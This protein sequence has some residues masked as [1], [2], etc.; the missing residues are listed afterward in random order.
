MMTPEQQQEPHL[1]VQP[2]PPSPTPADVSTIS[3]AASALGAVAAGTVGLFA[4]GGAF[5]APCA[6]A[7][8]CF[9][10][11]VAGLAA[12]ERSEGGPAARVVHM[13]SG[14][15]SA[16]EQAQQDAAAPPL[17]RVVE[18]EAP[19]SLAQKHKHHKHRKVE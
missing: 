7:G 19:A 9:G 5:I 11:A 12:A 10:G 3:H 8:A 16:T 4:F 6:L 18:E 17:P 15:V 1:E 14:T 2:A 13:A